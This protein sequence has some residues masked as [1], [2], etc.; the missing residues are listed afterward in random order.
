M[1]ILLLVLAVGGFFWLIQPVDKTQITTTD[2]TVNSGEGAR[3]VAQNLQTAGLIKNALAWRVWAKWAGETGLQAGVFSLSPAMSG[4]QIL[5]QLKTQPKEITITILPGWRREEIAEYL[6][7]LNLIN[8]TA[9][10]FL[11]LTTGMEGELMAETYRIFPTATAEE[12]VDLLNQQFL[13]DLAENEEIQAAVAKSGRSWVEILTVASLLQREARDY[14]QMRN[15]ATIIYRRLED[16]Y[17][18]QLCATAQYA[19]GKKATGGWWEP[20]TIEDTEF[21]SVYNTYAYKGL[22]PTPIAAVS[23]AAVEAALDPAENDYYFYLHDN[24]GKIHYAETLEEHTANK[25]RYL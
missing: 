9:T 8:F 23:V 18:L 2:F 13:R 16:N 3:A 14:E 25:E 17:P 5:Q 19:V 20:P 10:E 12:I 7:G 11:Q 24:D 6:D 4:E 22:P 15:I 1:A 21:D